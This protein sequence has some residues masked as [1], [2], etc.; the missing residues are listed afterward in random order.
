MDCDTITE[1]TLPSTLISIGSGAF[2]ASPDQ[3]QTHSWPGLVIPANV[4]TIGAQAFR[5]RILDGP[6]SIMPY[7]ETT[8]K[9]K[10]GPNKGQTETKTTQFGF[11]PCTLA[12]V[13]H[14]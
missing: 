12:H 1:L 13:Q 10:H 2:W 11:L 3:D 4:E 7:P 6:L 14:A 9:I 5:Q 8:S